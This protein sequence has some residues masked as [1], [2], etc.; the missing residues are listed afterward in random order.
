MSDAISAE[1]YNAMQRK[2]GSKYRAKR[3]RIDGHTFPSMAEGARYLELRQMVDAGLVRDL[4]LQPRYPIHVNGK[5]LCY[6]VADF[7]YEDAQTG[8]RHIEDVKGKVLPMYRL[9]A[10]AFALQYG[11]QITEVRGVDTSGMA[12]YVIGDEE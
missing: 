5:H 2:R 12:Q 8:T 4:I 9:K 11:R 6:V 10:K 3:V 7:E 1:E